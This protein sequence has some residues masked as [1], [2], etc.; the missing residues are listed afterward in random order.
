M[1]DPR[2]FP[3]DHAINTFGT[4]TAVSAIVLAG[5]ARRVDAEIVNDGDETIWL[6][7]GEDA[8]V[9]SGIRLNARGGSYR[10][11]TNNLFY[12]DIYGICAVGPV[13]ITVSDGWNDR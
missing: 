5:N 11:G 7:R 4:V 10:I 9:G 2:I 1:P 12:G 8:V 3:I 6:A 13:N